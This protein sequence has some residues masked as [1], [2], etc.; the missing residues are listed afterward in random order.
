MKEVT[1]EFTGLLPTEEITVVYKEEIKEYSIYK[2]TRRDGLF[3]KLCL[4][5]GNIISGFVENSH[6]EYFIDKLQSTS[7]YKLYIKEYKSVIDAGVCIK[8]LDMYSTNVSLIDY[9]R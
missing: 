1:G 6:V 2:S 5:S 8:L 3:F 9:I 7:I 4:R